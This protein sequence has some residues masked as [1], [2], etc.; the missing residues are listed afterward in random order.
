MQRFH[1]GV[2]ERPLDRL[3]VRVGDLEDAHHRGTGLERFAGV[4]QARIYS[5]FD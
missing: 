4:R 1:A 2:E 3:R 5:S